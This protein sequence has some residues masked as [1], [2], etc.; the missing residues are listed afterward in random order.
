MER[1]VGHFANVVV[2]AEAEEFVR[3]LEEVLAEG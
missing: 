3:V 2:E 1:C